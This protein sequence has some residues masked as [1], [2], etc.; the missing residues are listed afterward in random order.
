MRSRPNLSLLGV[1]LVFLACSDDPSGPGD[2]GSTVPAPPTGAAPA[3]LPILGR[4]PM[5][6]RHMAEVWVRGNTAYTTTWGIRSGNRGNAI[7]IWDV[8]GAAPKLVDSVFVANATT[9][10][11]VQLSDDGSV[12][13]VA[14]EHANGSIVVYGLSNPRKPQQLARFSSP[15]TT[16]GVHTATLATVGGKLYAFL[17]IDPGTSQLVI[18][19]LSTPSSPVQVLV[20]PMGAPFIHD[21]FVRGGMLFTAEWDDGIRIWDIGGGGKGGTVANPVEIGAVQTVNGAAHNL[22]WFHDSANGSKRY[23]FVGEEGPGAV[24][25][26]SSGDIHVIDIS[27]PALPLEVA[28]FHVPG[29]G[30]HNFS[31]DETR[32]V[33]YAAYYN[34]GVRALDVRGDLGACTSA[35]KSPD[36]RCDLGLMG[37]EMA[38]GLTATGQ[39]VYVWGVHYQ[40]DRVFASDM[41]NGLWKLSAIER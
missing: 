1:L 15:A 19:D 21:V 13:L 22:W 6:D 20:R 37:R 24:G 11:D 18:V 5:L 36:G 4:G 8:A 33:L 29:A 35:Q 23:V 28:F 3:T 30:T 38:R 16:A 40:S 31:V 9:L 14:T 39:P 25:N 34:A 12:M 27:N 26:S 32:G 17:A 7:H 10:G 41:L 2:G